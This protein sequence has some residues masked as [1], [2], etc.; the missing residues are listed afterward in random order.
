M[1]S[2]SY[3]VDRLYTTETGPSCSS[4]NCP[5]CSCPTGKVENDTWYHEF[6]DLY[7]LD[8]NRAE[9]SLCVC[10]KDYDG[11]L[12]ADCD[13]AKQEIN[14]TAKLSINDACKD[15]WNWQQKNPYGFKKQ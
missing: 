4:W 12:Y 2:Q 11:N 14:W 13:Y 15:A 9:C 10:K 6:Q 1:D 3:D 8:S 5:R 7:D